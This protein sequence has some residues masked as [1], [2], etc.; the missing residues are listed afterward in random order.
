MSD[1]NIWSLS[2]PRLPAAFR[3]SGG[4]ILPYRAYQDDFNRATKLAL[5]G[6]L[7]AIVIG[8]GPG[9]TA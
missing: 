9:Y 4:A 2:R 7:W 1:V 8:G 3:L 6:I 5:V